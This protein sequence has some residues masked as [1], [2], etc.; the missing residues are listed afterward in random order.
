MIS[1]NPLPGLATVFAI[2][3]LGGC[4][5][6]RPPVTASDLEAQ[7]PIRLRVGQP[8]AITLPADRNA[9]YA[10]HLTQT[11][12]EAL[13]LESD[14]TYTAE[15]GS[16]ANAG[17]AGSEIWRFVAVRKGRDELRFEYRAA[18]AADEKPD[19]TPMRVLRVLRYEVEAR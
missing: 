3:L 7:A 11:T 16:G 12:L 5:T 1:R 6:S 17:A 2:A 8:L 15:T 10:W 19:A 18:A 9:G 14:P 4:A 13:V